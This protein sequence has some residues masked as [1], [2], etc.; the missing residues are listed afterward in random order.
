MLDTILNSQVSY[1]HERLYM[2]NSNF[3]KIQ[4]LSTFLLLSFNSKS[5]EDSRQQVRI[6]LAVTVSRNFLCESC[7]EENEENFFDTTKPV[8]LKEY[9]GDL[10]DE[11][12]SVIFNIKK[13]D[14]GAEMGSRI[15]NRILL[16][17]R[18]GTGKSMLSKIIASE[19]GRT[20]FEKAGGSYTNKYKGSGSRSVYRLFDIAKKCGKSCIIFIYWA[21]G[22]AHKTVREENLE[23]IQTCLALR[24]KLNE[25]KNNPKLFVIL[26]TDRLDL[27]HKG[28]IEQC[29]LIQ[30]GL[31][32]YE[33]R[34]K[35]LETSL[36]EMENFEI[37]VDKKTLEMIAR[38]SEGFSYFDLEHTIY[39][40]IDFTDKIIDAL[41]LIKSFKHE[42]DFCVKYKGLPENNGASQLP[43]NFLE[44]CNLL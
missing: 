44:S 24:V 28:V 37:K 20:V 23:D 25:C 32:N 9:I 41:V 4:I 43:Y 21:D 19:T 33:H 11:I 39:N 8:E 6:P 2:V 5:M 30:L 26:V 34:L 10:P 7:R 14:E 22:I 12:K 27:I 42:K 1:Q 35:F 13:L 15:N 16:H 31:P 17:G 18:N 29:H 40:T 3:F 38:D 36:Q